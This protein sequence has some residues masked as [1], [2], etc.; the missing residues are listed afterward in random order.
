[1]RVL[2]DTDCRSNARLEGLPGERLSLS[3]ERKE[4]KKRTAQRRF[5]KLQL[6]KPQ[7]T[8]SFGQKRPRRGLQSENKTQQISTNSSHQLPSKLMEG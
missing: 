1:M 8:L 3:E 7:D 2:L 5:G 6:N 4:K